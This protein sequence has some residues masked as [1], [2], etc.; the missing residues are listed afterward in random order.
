MAS[1]SQVHSF[2]YLDLATCG[3][4]VTVAVTTEMREDYR[5]TY[6]PERDVNHMRAT[7]KVILFGRATHERKVHQWPV[8]VFAKTDDARAYATFLRLAYRAKDEGAIAALDPGHAK[9]SDDKIIFEVKWSMVTVPYAPLPEMDADS[10]AATDET[11][12]T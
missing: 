8:A 3:H 9:T 5:L 2:I 7:S 6:C 1:A 12:T 11:P 4:A 10:D